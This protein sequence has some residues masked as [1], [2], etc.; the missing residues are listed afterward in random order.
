MPAPARLIS[1]SLASQCTLFPGSL[2]RKLYIKKIPEITINVTQ[3]TQKN[4]TNRIE[5]PNHYLTCVTCVTCTSFSGKSYEKIV[6]EKDPGKRPQCDTS[7]TIFV[8]APGRFV[9]Y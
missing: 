7:V 6:Q 1:A 3:V 4:S 2:T 5:T 8:D 9:T